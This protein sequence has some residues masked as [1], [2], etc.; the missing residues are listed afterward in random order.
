MFAILH[1][2]GAFVASLFKSRRRLEVEYLFLRHQLN[3]AMRR[4]P[5]HLRLRGSDRAFLAWMTWL[6]PSLLSLAHVVQPETIL[7]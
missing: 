7:R 4:A 5:Y 2:L 6:W 1:F 3:I